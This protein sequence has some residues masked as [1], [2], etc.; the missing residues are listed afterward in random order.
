MESPKINKEAVKW[1]RLAAEQGLAQAQFNL[2]VLY[3]KGEGTA[4][5]IKQAVKW[6]RLAAEQGHVSAQYNLDVSS[7]S[8]Q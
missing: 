8:G 3:K 5:D 6:Y 1:L 4:Q 7:G 2:G